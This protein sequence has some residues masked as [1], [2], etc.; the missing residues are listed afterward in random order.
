M[1][2][3][4]LQPLGPLVNTYSMYVYFMYFYSVF[5]LS[6][7]RMLTDVLNMEVEYGSNLVHLKE[8]GGE[9]GAEKK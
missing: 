9:A 1:S 4:V 2:T 3:R 6:F 8:V 7:M 5:T